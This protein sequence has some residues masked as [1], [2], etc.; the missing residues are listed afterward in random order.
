MTRPPYVVGG[1][2]LL[3]GYSWAF[4][5]RLEQPVSQEL[6]R[7]HRAEQMARLKGALSKVVPI[8]S[9]RS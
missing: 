2:S 8:G 3:A 1:V 4:L 9:S 7:F 5:R 6:V